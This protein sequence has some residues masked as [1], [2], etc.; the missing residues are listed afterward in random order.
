MKTYNKLFLAIATLAF[1]SCKKP[2]TPEVT[3]VNSNLLVVE[4][5]INTGADS[6][7]FKLSRTVL[8]STKVATKPELAAV[9][10]VE[11]DANES[12]PL[13][14]KGAGIYI[15]TGLKVSSSKKYR[16]RIRT[17]KGTIYV[18]DFVESKVSPPID[19]V[20][21]DTNDNGLNVYVNTHDDAANSR[22]YRWEYQESWIFYAKYQSEFVFKNKEIV[23][24][25][26]TTEDIY[27]CWA[28]STSSTI[29]LGSSV[30]LA[31]DVI[32]KAPLTS[33]GSSSEKVSSKYSILVKQYVLTKEAFDFWSALKK[34]TESLGSIFDAQPSQLTGN[35]HNSSNTAEPVIGYVGAG[36]T[37]S[38]RIFI[39]AA[40]LPKWTVQYPVS[41]V[42]PDTV[43]INNTRTNIKA[44][45][46]F[47]DPS[48][49]ATGGVYT[50]TGT[51][52]GYLRSTRTCAD[53]TVRGT[54]KRPAFWQ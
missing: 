42:D 49:I 41:C 31:K 45:D 53:C 22:Y 32:N 28:G 36:T 52:E 38:L 11:S 48:N 35:V 21:W 15:H 19:K 13:T 9:V 18:S 54:N 46:V 26:Y 3:S 10:T 37:T 43:L 34:N 40:E 51:L 47:K 5:T 24:R 20:S 2:Y 30:K 33:I 7:I 23:Q 29:V 8:V 25:D 6:T 4:G 14:E 1:F 44:V 17:S 27:Q 39:S 16:V 12:Y 50:V